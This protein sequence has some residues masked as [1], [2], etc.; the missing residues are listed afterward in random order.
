M[1]E[2]EAIDDTA[3]NS[4]PLVVDVGKHTLKAGFGG[5]DTPTSVFPTMVGRPRQP[6]VMVG[7]N[8]KDAYVGDEVSRNGTV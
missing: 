2:A 8:Q 3:S 7:M 4:V 1:A 6:G 5:D